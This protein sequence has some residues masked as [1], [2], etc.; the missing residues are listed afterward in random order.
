M[1]QRL[2]NPKL[3]WWQGIL[4]IAG[5]VLAL[6]AGQLVAAVYSSLSESANA[7]A[8]ASIGFW[9]FGGAVAFFIMSAFVMEYEYTLDGLT[10]RIERIYGKTRP[11][12]AL[13]IITRNITFLGTPEEA[14]QK[15][16]NAHTANFTR[17]RAGIKITTV[18]YEDKNGVRL[19]NL[20]LNDELRARLL[21]IAKENGA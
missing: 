15:Y 2:S 7:Y 11:R 14:Q 10:L 1:R 19:A 5:I 17:A 9:I 13:Q 3:K 20:R 18:A 12:L 21:E 8:H 6:L 16:P 4:L